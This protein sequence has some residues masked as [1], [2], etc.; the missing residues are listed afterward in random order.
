MPLSLG[1]VPM[2]L[3][4]ARWC[5]FKVARL[6]QNMASISEIDAMIAE[7]YNSGVKID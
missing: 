2:G 4:H 5:G 6:L 7:R 1:R 3:A